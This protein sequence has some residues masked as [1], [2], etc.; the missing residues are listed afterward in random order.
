MTITLACLDMAGTTVSD[1]GVV[2]AAFDVALRVAGIEPES[3]RWAAAQ[4]VVVATMGQSKIEV[5]TRIL[6]DSA[7]AEHANQAFEVAYADAVAAGDV[8]E[9]PGARD[10]IDQLRDS[11]VQVCL[12]TGFSP[13]TRD[14]ILDALG[15]RDAV[16]LVLS[17][18]DAGRGRP[19]P[20]MI[21]TAALRLQAEA[22]SAVLVAGDTPSDVEA[23]RRAGAGLVVGVMTGTGSAAQLAAAHADEIVPDVGAIPDLIR[24]GRAATLA[25]R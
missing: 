6:G 21:W 15:W 3:T 22:M 10:A 13:R 18:A 9:T 12:T 4:Q 16:D 1:G 7:R 24:S 17:P 8:A 5:F 20:D 25:E 2:M 23:G 14:A 19:W 11:G